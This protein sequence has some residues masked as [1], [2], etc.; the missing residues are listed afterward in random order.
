MTY[1][2][3]GRDPAG[4]E[5]G[6]AVQSRWFNAGQNVAWI[7]PGV[8]AVCTQAIVEPAYGQRGLEL[9]R[10]GRT[11]EQALATLAS[12]DPG[13]D[14]RQVAIAD[15]GGRFAQ[16][17]G[18]ACVDAAGHA[19]RAD[20]CAPGNMLASERCWD[21]M[22]DAFEGTVAALAD[23]L[24]V[25]LDAAER[26]GGDARGR[27]AARLLVCRAEST[28]P[29]W[30]DR[31]FD[32]QVVDHSEP[33]F[34]LRRLVTVKRAYDHLG[35]AFDLAGRDAAAAAEEA[36]AAH[37]LAPARSD[38]LLAG[39]DAGGRRTARRGAGC[40]RRGRRGAPRLAGLP[41]QLRGRRPRAARSA[42]SGGRARLG[43]DRVRH[44]SS[45]NDRLTR[46][47]HTLDGLVRRDLTTAVLHDLRSELALNRIDRRPHALPG[48]ADPGDGT[49]ADEVVASGP[50]EPF[51]DGV[52]VVAAQVLYAR[53]REWALTA[54]DIPRR[55]TT[56]ARG[57]GEIPT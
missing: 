26:E 39:D 54:D 18:R 9:L 56:L 12:E 45:E 38:R 8:G 15:L 48:A 35:R 34:E 46:C 22:V 1:S 43:H 11:P 36:D 37:E 23:R 17:T 19:S 55:R 57:P 16:H 3:I 33:L 32:L 29:P 52:T 28:G 20:C 10:S 24:L 40:L 49:L 6:I 51:A 50:F 21:A 13:R 25:A 5:I 41:A 7:E 30:Q 31:I 47:R 44:E 2:I 4:G 14:V 53:H 42:S 27:Q